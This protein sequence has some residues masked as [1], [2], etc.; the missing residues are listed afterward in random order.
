M[1]TEEG[2]KPQEK[3]YWCL[4]CPEGAH[5]EIYCENFG[6]VCVP[7]ALTH[8][9]WT[10]L[11]VA[12]IIKTLSVPVITA[13]IY[14]KLCRCFSWKRFQLLKYENVFSLSFFISS[15]DQRD[16][17]LTRYAIS[18]E[19][20]CPLN[21]DVKRQKKTWIWEENLLS[22]SRERWGEEVYNTL[23]AWNS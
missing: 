8:E 7:V 5:S 2:W 18:T 12:H 9:A 4:C 16:N 15:W 19:H 17:T 6:S 20:S 10:H 22:R 1:H 21:F 3:C 11:P 23:Y 13:A 14:P